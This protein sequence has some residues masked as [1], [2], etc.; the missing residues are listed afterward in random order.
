MRFRLRPA[1]SGDS[2]LLFN[3]HRDAMQVLVSAVFGE[4]DDA[5]QRDLHD[6]WFE[7]DLVQV[8]EV[9]ARPVGMIAVSWSGPQVE[10]HRLEVESA[11]RGQGL[12]TE[13]MSFILAEADLR[14]L[15]TV[16]EVFRIN[17]ARGLYERLGFREVSRDD[18]KVY[19]MR[20]SPA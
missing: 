16:L 17:R 11:R 3:L 7:P 4:W 5:V 20:P 2:D 10:I 14:G 12:G 8:V 18:T 9:D 1:R 19:L 15:A 6:A 13:L